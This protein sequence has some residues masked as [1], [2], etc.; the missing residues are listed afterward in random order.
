MHFDLI[1]CDIWGAYYVKSF[2]GASYFLTILDDASRC[3]WVYLMREKSEASQIVKDFCAMVQTQFKTKVRTIRSD[4]GSEFVSG[5]MKNFYGEQEIIHETSSVDTPQQNGRVERKH[6]H[7]LNVARALRFE[8]HLRLEFWGECVLTVA[9]LINRTPTQVL[10]GK[11]PYEALFGTKP[12]YEHLKFVDVC[13]MHTI[14][15]EKRTN[16]VQEVEGAFLLV[17]HMGKRVGRFTI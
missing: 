1:H 11:T 6:R 9:H 15:K 2:C 16:L 14:C 4:N 5:P 7:V 3:V 13:V 8:A 10:N 17:I 12:S